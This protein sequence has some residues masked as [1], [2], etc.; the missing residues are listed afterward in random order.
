MTALVRFK[1]FFNESNAITIN[2]YIYIYIYIL[3]VMVSLK[4][5]LEL[6]FQKYIKIL[7]YINFIKCF[8]KLYM[9]T[10]IFSD[11]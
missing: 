2:I 8:A 3:I 10:H 9:F 1:Y 4:I 7:L 5:F 6:S 11:I